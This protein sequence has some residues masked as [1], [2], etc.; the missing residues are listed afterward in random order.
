MA[1]IKQLPIRQRYRKAL[2]YISFLLFPLTLYYFSPALILQGG[3]EGIVNG[4]FIVFGL[5]FVAALFLGR[6][7]CGWACPAGALQEF[8]TPINNKPAPGGRF[9]WIKWI[10]VWI[11]WISLIAVLAIPGYAIHLAY[12][13]QLG[14]GPPWFMIYY[15][16]IALFLGLALIFGRR[17]GCHYLCWM[18]PFMIIGRKIRNVFRWP[19]LR[20]RA[21]SDKC[22]DCRR[23]SRECVMGLDVNGLVRD[24]DMEHA[25]C[26]LCGS[27]V[28]NCPKQ[29]IR[30]S[31][32]SGK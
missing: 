15:I 21:A 27:C 23:C 5:M 3:S 10:V 17:G 18:A 14:D 20:L 13:L 11:P 9:D 30:Y 12:V 24:G 28:D 22:I 7:W 26:V 32:S 19:A 2:L 4:S 29:V 16:V 25:E 31:F 8:A 1:R 6:L